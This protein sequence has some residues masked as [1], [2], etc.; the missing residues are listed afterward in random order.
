[1]TWLVGRWIGSAGKSEKKQKKLQDMLTKN[2]GMDMDGETS[3]FMAAF[4]RS[5][6]S[7]HPQTVG[8][9]FYG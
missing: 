7:L 8:R 1:M 4:A 3:A 9:Q 5:I 6:A 2:F